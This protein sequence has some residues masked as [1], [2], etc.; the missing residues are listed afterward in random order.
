MSTSTSPSATS[1]PSPSTGTEIEKNSTSIT[2]S[3]FS[4]D[5]YVEKYANDMIA[6]YK[7]QKANCEEQRKLFLNFN[8]DRI[9]SFLSTTVEKNPNVNLTVIVRNDMIICMLSNQY[10]QFKKVIN[11]LKHNI[12]DGSYILDKSDNKF[13]FRKD[14]NYIY[15]G[16]TSNHSSGNAYI[17]SDVTSLIGQ[18]LKKMGMSLLQTEVHNKG[19]ILHL[20]SINQM[21]L[22]TFADPILNLVN[23]Y[24][25]WKCINTKDSQFSGYII[26]T[27]KGI[28]CISDKLYT[29]YNFKDGKIIDDIFMGNVAQISSNKCPPNTSTNIL[30]YQE[31]FARNIKTGGIS[32]YDKDLFN[33]NVRYAIELIERYFLKS[34]LASRST[35]RSD[36][37]LIHFKK[38]F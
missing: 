25:K 3:P 37:T 17:V 15:F 24:V 23:E 7:Q 8:Q 34:G 20:R 35:Y 19:Y 22:E 5:I 21:F 36:Y 30:C 10:K 27:A 38:S 31:Y 2:T 18:N 33:D 26:I 1:S 11:L 4:P 13:T 9:I 14:V 32:T 29:E 16:F 6:V 28:I 12:V